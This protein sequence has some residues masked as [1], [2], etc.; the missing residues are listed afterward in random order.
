MFVLKAFE[1]TKTCLELELY[2][3][4]H[5]KKILNNFL[6]TYLHV[7]IPRDYFL[8]KWSVLQGRSFETFRLLPIRVDRNIQ[9]LHEKSIISK[10]NNMR[11]KYTHLKMYTYNYYFTCHDEFSNYTNKSIY[12]HIQSLILINFN[13]IFLLIILSYQCYSV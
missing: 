8:K 10:S 1:E 3:E 5:L 2:I 9:Q 6:S 13:H 11:E 12:L 7:F 4:C